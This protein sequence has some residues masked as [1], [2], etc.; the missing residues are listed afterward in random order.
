MTVHVWLDTCAAMDIMRSLGQRSFPFRL[1][2]AFERLRT[3]GTHA[4]H[5]SENTRKEMRENLPRTI[6]GIREKFTEVQEMLAQ[7][8]DMGLNLKPG[9]SG[10]LLPFGFD[11]QDL[12]NWL[13]ALQVILLDL[14][15][16]A[17]TEQVSLQAYRRNAA[18]IAPNHKGSNEL[19]DCIIWENFLAFVRQSDPADQFFFVTSN[20]KDFGNPPGD[21][22]PLHKDMYDLRQQG[23][24]VQVVQDVT[25][26]PDEERE[27]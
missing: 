20:T 11:E 15:E 7:Y 21:R 16:E 3:N 10:G 8:Q 13:D 25:L 14:P 9:F 6:K 23:F 5:V 22:G 27:A 12:D 19:E 18:G 4:F 26:I 2:Q 24:V 17:I 1:F